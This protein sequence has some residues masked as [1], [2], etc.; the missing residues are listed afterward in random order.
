MNTHARYYR[1][2]SC[3][4]RTFLLK[5]WAKNR[6]CGLYTRPFLS[7]RANWFVV[8]T[9]WTET[10]S[11][12]RLNITK[13]VVDHCFRWLLNEPF[14]KIFRTVLKTKS[15]S[16]VVLSR[17]SCFTLFEELNSNCHGTSI[18]PHRQR[19]ITSTLISPLRTRKYHTIRENLRGK[20][21]TVSSPFTTFTACLST[22][23]LNSRLATSFSPI[24]GVNMSW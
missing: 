19:P 22:V 17:V 21:P 23:L 3:I 4:S 1:K 2:D 13:P 9:N 7:G 18:L 20:W 5:F 6:G 12:Q 8:V 16:P 10:F 24:D 11:K 14:V 15:C